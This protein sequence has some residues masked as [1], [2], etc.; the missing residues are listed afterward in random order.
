MQ[1]KN[2]CEAKQLKGRR[3]L[4]IPAQN[5]GPCNDDS[6]TRPLLQASSTLK[7]DETGYKD[8]IDETCWTPLNVSYRCT[9]DILTTYIH[10]KTLAEKEVLTYNDGKKLEVISLACGLVGG[11]A[12]QSSIGVSMRILIPQSTKDKMRYQTLSSLE[13]VIGKVPIVHI[14][15]VIAAHV[16]CMENTGFTC[17]FL[18]VS[19]RLKSAEI[20]TLMQSCWPDI[21]IPDE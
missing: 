5:Q 6:F 11:Y 16:L 3:A 21:T 17:R 8:T 14:E 19:D 9:T 13:E 20:A 15:D 1:Y 7:D 18:C 2:I 12:I 10:S 4:R